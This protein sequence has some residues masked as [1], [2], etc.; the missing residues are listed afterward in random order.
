M[1][2][3]NDGRPVWRGWAVALMPTLAVLLFVALHRWLAGPTAAGLSFL[4]VIGVAFF[5]FPR[6]KVDPVKLVL[7]LGVAV[8]VGA[9]LG[10]WLGRV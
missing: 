10:V 9:G 2:D 6:L 5:L 3:V 1:A 4:A 8:M 7:G